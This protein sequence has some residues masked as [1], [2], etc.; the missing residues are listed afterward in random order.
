MSAQVTPNTPPPALRTTALKQKCMVWRYMNT[1]T[2]EYEGTGKRDVL[3]KVL[4][5]TL[6][7]Q[8]YWAKGQE[9]GKELGFQSYNDRSNYDYQKCA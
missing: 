5:Q 2:L 8:L 7:R 1:T 3:T 6:A 4:F 9:K